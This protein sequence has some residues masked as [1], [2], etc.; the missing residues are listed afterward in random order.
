M[1]TAELIRRKR[2]G[3]EL[4]AEEISALVAG[5]ADGSVSDAQ[6]GALAMAIFL[7]GHDRP[8]ARGTDGRDDPVGRGA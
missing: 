4:S 1:L 2:D 6:V 5:I 7:A 3:E 8:R